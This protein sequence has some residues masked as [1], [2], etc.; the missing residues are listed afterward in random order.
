MFEQ[1][2]KQFSQLKDGPFSIYWK[3]KRR[4]CANC[5]QFKTDETK[6][7]LEVRT[8]QFE[9]LG[10]CNGRIINGGWVCDGHE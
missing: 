1:P 2:K 3:D 9:Y 6:K 5:R 10:E 8:D 7:T 4:K